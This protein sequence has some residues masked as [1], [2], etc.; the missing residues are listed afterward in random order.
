VKAKVKVHFDQQTHKHF[1]L[2]RASADIHS[3][4]DWTRAG[5]SSRNADVG[6][7]CR[8]NGEFPHRSLPNC[9]ADAY[10]WKCSTKSPS[11]WLE[12]GVLSDL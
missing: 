1:E 8:T 3:R 5:E 4:R 9:P 7:N 11:D 2:T 10:C 12:T 6:V